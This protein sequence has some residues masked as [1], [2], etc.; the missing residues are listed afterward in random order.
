MRYC[1][2]WGADD[3]DYL[4]RYDGLHAIR[5]NPIGAYALGLA[6]DYQPPVGTTAPERT[7]KVLPTLD[8]V[9]VGEPTAADRLILDAHAEHTSDRVWTI[10]AETLLARIE[11]GRR[12]GPFVTFLTDRATHDLPTALTVLVNDVTTRATKIRDRGLVRLLECADAPLATLIARDPKLRALFTLVGDHHLAVPVEHET[13]FRRTLHTLGHTITPRPGEPSPRGQ[14]TTSPLLRQISPCPPRP[15]S[16]RRTSTA[17]AG[18]RPAPDAVVPYQ[19]IRLDGITVANPRR[20]PS[21]P[22]WTRLRARP[23]AQPTTVESP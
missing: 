23:R 22:P 3:L 13:Q 8:I 11:T 7:L 5:L 2:N 20:Q 15:R 1:H 9:A 14:V 6:G 4:S 18:S 19:S 10:R 12:L 17:G 21:D 16:R